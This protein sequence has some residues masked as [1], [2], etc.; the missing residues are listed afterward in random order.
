MCDHASP[1]VF[2]VKRYRGLFFSSYCPNDAASYMVVPVAMPQITVRV[3][4]ADTCGLAGTL[5]HTGYRN[6]AH[7][8][9]E[10]A[11]C[12]LS[13]NRSINNTATGLDSPAV[14]PSQNTKQLILIFPQQ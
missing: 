9:F 10:K 6:S 2:V 7:F 8:P 5:S 11:K 13:T 4:V 14:F 1:S 12:G 3:L